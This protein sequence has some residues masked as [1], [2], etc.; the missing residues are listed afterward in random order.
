MYLDSLSTFDDV[1]KAHGNRSSDRTGEKILSL[2][3]LETFLTSNLEGKTS[4]D[5][6]EMFL[7]AVKKRIKQFSIHACCMKNHDCF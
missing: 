7:L 4:A 1:L 6:K 2:I 3:N 5:Q